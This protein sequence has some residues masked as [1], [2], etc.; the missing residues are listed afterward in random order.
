MAA[1]EVTPEDENLVFR[2]AEK[3]RMS[4]GLNANGD[5]VNERSPGLLDRVWDFELRTC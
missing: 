4:R 2:I 5:F 1:F 3:S